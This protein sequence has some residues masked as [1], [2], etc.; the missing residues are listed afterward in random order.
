MLVKNLMALLKDL[1]PN[2]T[3]GITYK[4]SDGDRWGVEYVNVTSLVSIDWGANKLD[5][6]L[7]EV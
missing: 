7:E 4:D 1:P 3:I 6:Y 2:A 5:Y